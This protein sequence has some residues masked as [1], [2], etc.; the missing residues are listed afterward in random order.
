M[1]P[2]WHIAF[3]N[4]TITEYAGITYRD[5]YASPATAL[6]AQLKASEIMEAR[7]GV[8]KFIGP[9]IDTPAVTFASFLGMPI[10]V[11]DADELPFVDVSV[12]LIGDVADLDRL[13]IRDPKTT[14][15]MA[16]RWE[17]WQYYTSRGH[18]VRF[19]GH[20]G[21]VVTTA[22][23]ISGDNALAWLAEKPEAAGRVL[24][25]VVEANHALEDF[26]NALCGHG[27][28]GYIGDDFAGLL[29]PAMFREFVIPRYE[30]IYAGKTSR[31]MHSELL[32]AEHLRI[33]RDLLQITSFHGAGSKNLTLQEQYDIMGHDFWAQVT[34]Q[35]LH[36]FS[37]EAISERIK[38]FANCGASYVQLYPGRGTPERN[39]EAAISA[40]RNECAGGPV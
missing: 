6:E 28:G 29:S 39:M 23:E 16:K 31:F 30:R 22:C 25:F 9:R 12:P 10:V 24:D 37:P 8:G 4:V 40:A 15:L 3:C 36:E 2:K 11:P 5:Y 20:G 21:S 14:G 19:G 13:R 1:D 26:D 38:E 18:K 27:S 33:A 32:R 7:F 17:A 34:P 35:E